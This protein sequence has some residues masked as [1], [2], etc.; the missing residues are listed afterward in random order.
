[1]ALATSFGFCSSFG[2]ISCH[3]CGVTGHIKACCFKLHPELKQRFAQNHGTTCT[4][5]IVESVPATVPSSVPDPHLLQT[6]IGQLQA[7]LGS[8]TTHQS[9][10]ST[11]TLATGPEF[12]EDFW[13]WI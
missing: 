8:L 10:P 13:Q 3:H 4:A 2:K 7:H 6:Q 1:M 12:K 9:G 11:T 5:A